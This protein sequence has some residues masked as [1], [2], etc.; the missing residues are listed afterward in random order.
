MVKDLSRHPE[1]RVACAPVGTLYRGRRAL[2]ERYEL[3]FSWDE[4]CDQCNMLKDRYKTFTQILRAPGVRCV[5]LTNHVHATDELWHQMCE[6]IYNF[7]FISITCRMYDN[8]N[9]TKFCLHL[10]HQPW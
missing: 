4:I 3:N 9:M 5:Q 1:E 8:H 2:N 10:E 6:V 7:P